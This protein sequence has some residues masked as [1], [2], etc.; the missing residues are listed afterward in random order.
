VEVAAEKIPVFESNP[1]NSHDPLSECFAWATDEAD[2]CEILLRDSQSVKDGFELSG[3]GKYVFGGVMRG[4][5]RIATDNGPYRD[6]AGL[7][8]WQRCFY[9]Y[10]DKI[11]HVGMPTPLDNIY[12]YQR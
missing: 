2:A 6:S 11:E 8:R 3:V 9:P 5:I 12:V 1:P 4:S 10:Y 7:Y